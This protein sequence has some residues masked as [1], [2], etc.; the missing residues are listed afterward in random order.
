MCRVKKVLKIMNI[1]KI[2]ISEKK[3]IRE[4]IFLKQ[5]TCSRYPAKKEKELLK[6]KKIKKEK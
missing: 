5:G 3:K 2:I 1:W 6:M 4:K